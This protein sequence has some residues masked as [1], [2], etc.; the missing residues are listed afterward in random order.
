MPIPNPT[1]LIIPP[2]PGEEYDSLW[3]HNIMIN[4]PTINSGKIGI[5]TLPYD[6]TNQKL[7]DISFLTS[8]TTDNLWGAVNEVPEVASAMNAIFMAV[9]PLIKWIES[10]Q[11]N[12][13]QINVPYAA[14]QPIIYTPTTTPVISSSETLPIL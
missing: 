4:A 11:S 9:D 7:A 5:E 13:S 14:I 2:T 3:L 6:P 1:P 10:N 12:E 8:I